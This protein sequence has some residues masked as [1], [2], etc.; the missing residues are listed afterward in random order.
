[1]CAIWGRS[2]EPA[3]QT[4]NSSVQPKSEPTCPEW[5]QAARRTSC[6]SP[7]PRTMW[8][9]H[10]TRALANSMRATSIGALP[11]SA[12]WRASHTARTTD[13]LIICTWR[14]EV[15]PQC[16]EF[17]RSRAQTTPTPSGNRAAASTC[18]RWGSAASCAHWATGA[19]FSVANSSRQWLQV[20]AVNR[21]QYTFGGRTHPI[22]EQTQRIRR[23]TVASGKRDMAGCRFRL[24]NQEAKWSSSTS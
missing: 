7:T 8:C 4:N 14:A 10:S 19:W 22:R 11:I 23:A 15:M 18:E 1:M 9:A 6:F 16:T 5:R 20:L 3:G 2:N 21:K 17:A 13:T 24:Q 12:M